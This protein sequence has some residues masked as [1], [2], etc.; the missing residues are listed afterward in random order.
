MI[1]HDDIIGITGTI[2]LIVAYYLTTYQLSSNLIL[3]DSLNVYGSFAVGYNCIYKGTYPPVILEIV[4]FIIGTIS[5]VKNIIN[6]PDNNDCKTKL[7][8]THNNYQTV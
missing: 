4:W 3:I 8:T 5:L 7:V 1:G 2:C 6:P